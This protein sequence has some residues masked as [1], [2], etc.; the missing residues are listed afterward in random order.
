MDDY[1]TQDLKHQ[2][3]MICCTSSGWIGR[4]LSET[5]VEMPPSLISQDIEAFKP[6]NSEIVYGNVVLVLVAIW[7][8]ERTWKRVVNF[9]FFFFTNDI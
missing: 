2:W 3:K 7:Q 6:S 8:G 1:L 5:I 9:F 4:A